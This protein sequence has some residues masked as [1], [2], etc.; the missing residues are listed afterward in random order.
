MEHRVM[1]RN[2][3]KYLG[4]SVEDIGSAARFLLSEDARY[5][6]GHTLMV[7]GGSCPVT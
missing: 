4:D 1:E 2:P 6:T 3:L 7:D 5:I